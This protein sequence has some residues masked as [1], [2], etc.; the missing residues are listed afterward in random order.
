MVSAGEVVAFLADNPVVGS[1]WIIENTVKTEETK[2]DSGARTMTLNGR[3]EMTI[4][5]KTTEGFH[6]SYVAPEIS[7]EGNSPNV[8]LLRTYCKMLENL[9]IRATI[10][11][12]GKPIRIDNLDAVK[13]EMHVAMD[14]LLKSGQH[15]QRQL[16][17]LGMM[18]SDLM[19]MDAERAAPSFLTEMVTLAKS[20]NT[21]MKMGEVRRSTGPAD[22]P[23]GTTLRSQMSFAL[24][25]TDVE[26]RTAIYHEVRA[27]DEGSV[28]DFIFS[29]SKAVLA[30]SIGE[31]TPERLEHLMKGTTMT[32]DGKG[33]FLVEN[34]MTH[35]VEDTFSTV[36][37]VAGK[38]S[39][40]IESKTI[41]V[42]AAP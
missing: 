38:V 40:K 18:M 6:I 16:L 12:A 19:T 13:A 26:K 2:P 3:A 31:V 41:K 36:A 42:T 7:V 8:P 28:R 25:D 21:G 37:S 32:L 22:N 27:F 35:Q 20:Q 33:F 14:R 23:L 29:H 30:K 34:G 1:R 39:T 4:D 9:L 10:D 17:A 11:A 24:S 5:E 15:S